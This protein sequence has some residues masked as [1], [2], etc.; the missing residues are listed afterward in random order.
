[1]QIPVI[2]R[3]FFAADHDDH[4]TPTQGDVPPHNA[5][6]LQDGHAEIPTVVSKWR[7]LEQLIPRSQ[8][9]LLLLTSLLDSSVDR[10]ATTTLVG[11]DAAV[12]L[13]ILA[14]VRVIHHLDRLKNT[15]DTFGTHLLP[16]VGPRQPRQG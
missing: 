11:E 2:F 13:D 10:R 3:Q 8:Q 1:M 14:K 15:A 16:P 4:D 6:R 12:V 7:R 9:Y 5:P